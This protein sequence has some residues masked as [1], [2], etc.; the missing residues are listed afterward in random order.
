MTEDPAVRFRQ[1][2][3]NPLTHLTWFEEI[4]RELGLSG[5]SQ[6]WDEEPA[7]YFWLG[8]RAYLLRYAGVQ[9]SATELIAALHAFPTS[10]E[11]AGGHYDEIERSLLSAEHFDFAT[12]T[13]RFESF[14]RFSH[15]F[16]AGELLLSLADE[17]ISALLISGHDRSW[18]HVWSFAV[19]FVAMQIFYRK[20]APVAEPFVFSPQAGILSALVPFDATGAHI[21]GIGGGKPGQRLATPAL[22]Q[23]LSDAKAR[24]TA[25]GACSCAH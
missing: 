1:L 2:V 17:E 13:P 5:I 6:I 16:L 15:A 3:E 14:A 19:F 11:L 12:M 10:A 24:C 18:E 22:W 9:E 8:G 4:C 25:A 20:A 23:Q 7:W 21:D